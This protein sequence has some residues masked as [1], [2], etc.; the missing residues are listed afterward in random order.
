MFGFFKRKTEI[1]KL[2]EKYKLLI[3]QAYKLS[4]TDREAS[5]LKTVEAEALLAKIEQLS[6]KRN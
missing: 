3:E 1:E 2:E 4:H 5:S 6:Q